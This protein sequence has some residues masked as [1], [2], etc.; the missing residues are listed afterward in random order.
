MP[1]CSHPNYT[2]TYP[3]IAALLNMEYIPIA[4]TNT[5]EEQSNY[6]NPYLQN[7]EVCQQLKSV[8]YKTVGYQ[9]EEYPLLELDRSDVLIDVSHPDIR[10]EY[11]YPFEVLYKQT[12]ATIIYNALDPTGKIA[13]FFSNL[14]EKPNSPTVD[15]SVLSGSQKDFASLH[16]ESP[17]SSSII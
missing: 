12:T 3:S 13:D 9:E 11:L 6:F 15:L 1:S 2:F 14:D 8:G 16:A 4:Y 10:T 17:C 7:N 5:E